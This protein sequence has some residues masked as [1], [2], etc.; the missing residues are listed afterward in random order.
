MATVRSLRFLRLAYITR[1]L[2]T[3]HAIS[4]HMFSKLTSTW[5][6]VFQASQI[7]ALILWLNHISTCIWFGLGRLLDEGYL[8]TETGQSWLRAKVGDTDV[9]YAEVSTVFQYT[10]SMHWS[11]SQMTPGSMN[12]GPLNSYERAWNIVALVFGLLFGTSLVSQLSSKMV[13]FNMSRQ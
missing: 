13:Q 6:I 9:T 8:T 3:V 11:L 12:V 7:L 2:K 4:K 5:S 10:T 1:L